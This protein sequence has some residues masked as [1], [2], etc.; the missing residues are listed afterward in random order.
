MIQPDLADLDAFTAVARARGFRAAAVGRRVS[1]STLSQAVRRLED[2]LGVRLLNRTTRSVSLTEAG[3]RLL[4]RLEPALGGVASALE[5]V[6]AFRDTPL[7]T[8]R[9]NV[10][11]VVA[12]LILPP[13]L[14]PFLTANPGVTAEVV[15]ED[16]FIDIFA[17]GFDAGVR[18][19]EA[20]D[21]D[22]IA[23]PIGP[24]MRF[25]LLASPGYLAQRGTPAHPSDL[26]AHLA[27]R[28]RFPSGSMTPWE[29]E[30][31]GEIVRLE[32]PRA[33]LVTNSIDALVCA[34]VDGV[35][36]MFTF[37]GFAEAQLADGRLVEVMADWSQSFPGPSLY[38]P[39]R[40]LAPGPLR[41]F[42]DFVRRR[43]VNET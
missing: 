36:L 31:D 3:A 27:V 15:V 22:M 4:E 43:R 21:Q 9:L 28:H 7:G 14:A 35:G 34:A 37:P 42:V 40:R 24:P 23:V 17:A 5:A 20:L 6:N 41:A 18:F 19:D 12:R 39:S 26:A 25:A 8:L 38:Y 33:P 29:F 1:A 32:P 10:S 16:S 11:G 2:Q 30:R 13:L